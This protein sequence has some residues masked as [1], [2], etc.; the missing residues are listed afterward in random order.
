MEIRN[1]EENA[2]LHM[3]LENINIWPDVKRLLCDR[4][5]HGATP[6]M[7]ALLMQNLRG[8][9]LILLAIKQDGRNIKVATPQTQSYLT[10]C[11]TVM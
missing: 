1:E 7:S 4:D 8:A 9:Y 3:L 11:L 2:I 10:L 6:F 5:A